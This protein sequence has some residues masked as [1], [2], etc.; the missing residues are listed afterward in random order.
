MRSQ[1]SLST[2]ATLP[3]K[4]SHLPQLESKCRQP[5]G[6]R[7][8][9]QDPRRDEVEQGDE[10]Y[11]RRPPALEPGV[12]RQV[13]AGW[14]IEQRRVHGH[15][16]KA[17]RRGHHQQY[18]R[19]DT[20][21]DEYRAADGHD[22]HDRDVDLALAPELALPQEV[23]LERVACEP[24]DPVHNTYVGRQEHNEAGYE[25]E[26]RE[27]RRY[28]L[29]HGCAPILDELQVRTDVLLDAYARE[30][31]YAEGDEQQRADEPE[32]Y[33]VLL[34]RYLPPLLP[35]TTVLLGVRR[36]VPYRRRGHLLAG[37]GGDDVGDVEAHA[38]PLIPNVVALH[39]VVGAAG[40]REG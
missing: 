23:H 21:P 20:S 19:L 31:E 5:L 1:N 38:H 30:D 11:Y 40:T 37:Y 25:E 28:A 9:E 8:V 36:H 22:P 3:L 4:R 10:D 7:Q 15:D 33:E 17:S 34:V 35:A 13:P 24:A 39:Q 29:A 6:R 2:L 14:Y 16:V 26:L 27:P 18:D 32:G 12:L